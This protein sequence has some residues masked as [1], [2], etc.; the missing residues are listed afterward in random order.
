MDRIYESSALSR[1]DEDP[2]APNERD[3]QTK[4]QSFRS[5]SSAAWSDRL[6]PHALRRRLVSVAVTTPKRVFER[7]EPVPFEVTMRNRLPIPVTIE[8]VSPVRWTWS[9]EGLPEASHVPTH[10]PPDEPASLHFDRSERKRFR[11]DWSGMF[12]VS[13]REWERAEP[14]E[15]TIAAAINVEDPPAAG[16]SDEQTVRIRP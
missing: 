9:V 3:R 8:T 10:D 13:D 16:L 14:G 12:R 11:R 15:Y 1:D 5:I 4:P 6:V 2:F 7:G